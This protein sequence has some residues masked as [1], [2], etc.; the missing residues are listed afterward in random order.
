MYRMNWL[1][2]PIILQGRKVRLEPLVSGHFSALL[3]IAGDNPDIWTHLPVYGADGNLL[4]QELTS[5]LLK[6]STGEQYPFV[7]L[8]VT[9]DNTIIGST[10]FLNIFPEHRKLEIGWT[11]YDPAYW[12]SGHN[13]ECKLLLLEYCFE[14]LKAIRVQLQASEKNARS[15]AAIQKVGGQL[16]GILRNDRIRPDGTYRDTAVYSIID[17]EWAGVKEMLEG[18]V[19]NAAVQ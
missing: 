9:N 17:S 13:V 11:W 10:R 6:R 8:D 14:T 19:G 3:Q 18:K 4:Q 2:A 1:Q 16:E 12:G 15:R 5:A 7:I